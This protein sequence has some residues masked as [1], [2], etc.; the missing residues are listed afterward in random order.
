ML[1]FPYLAKPLDLGFTRLK[2]R[3][4]MGSMHTG[5]ED[6]KDFHRL[7]GYFEERAR[8]GVALMVTG[9]FAPNR[10]GWLLPFA[11]KLTTNKEVNKHKTL[12]ERIH[13]ADS[14]IICQILHAGRYAFHP[15]SVAPSALKSPITPFTPT[16]MS[17]G[18]IHSTIQDFANTAYRARLA[19]Y[20]GV[21]IMGSEGYLI[22]E[23]LVTHTNHRQD[24]WGGDFTNRMRFA[25]E[26]VKATR[27]RV[28]PDFI[29]IFRLSMIDLIEAGSS[30][31]EVVLLAKSLESVGVTL[32]NTG[33]GWHE[34]RVPTIATCVPRALFSEVTHRLKKEVTI[35]VIVSNRINDPKVAEELLAQGC[36]DL[37]SMARPFLADPD[38]VRKAFSG[39]ARY[40]NTCIACN[41]ACLDHAFQKK[42]ATCLVNPRACHETTF[43]I[44][45]TQRS[46]RIAVI[47]G[48]PAGLS[49]ALVAATRGHRVTL[50]EKS[51]QLG[52]Q[53]NLAKRIPGK[54][55]YEQTIRYYQESLRA[56]FVEVVLN[57]RVHPEQMLSQ[58]FDD[59][60]IATGVSPR[61][62]QIKGIDHPKVMNYIDA[63]LHPER[64]GYKVVIVGAGGI[65]FDVATLLTTQKS[66]TVA[67]F[68]QEWGIDLTVQH[69]GGV[70][71][72]ILTPPFRDVTLMQRKSG[73]VGEHL[74]KTTG[75]I[76]RAHLKHQ[77]VTM[78]AGVQYLEIDDLGIHIIHEKKTQHILADTIVICAGQSPNQQL[79]TALRTAG[80]STHVIGGAV[81]ALELDAKRAILEGAKL[82][83]IL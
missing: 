2:N 82:A 23:F 69:R 7:A 29:L 28:G 34:A 51:S 21:E 58:K 75:W 13:A 8:G 68:C 12:T 79:L 16:A 73:K 66:Q 67:Q 65:G 30:W 4:I 33:I 70:M 74:G 47:G 61:M 81:E 78:M 10:R 53:F 42:I 37:I 80:V 32:L 11:A 63:I 60:I 36:A 3:F 62:P 57:H 17:S 40:I 48:G 77:A 27:L 55:E 38:F 22:N 19:G 6:D 49:A 15:F 26:I 41:Q 59:L 71:P 24:E 54:E 64:V 76:H 44:E 14:K 83:A 50:F 35:P 56:Q 39:R 45:K 31:E 1:P 5:L 9:G 46:K 25:L 20:D 52:G 43:N 72:M 18:L